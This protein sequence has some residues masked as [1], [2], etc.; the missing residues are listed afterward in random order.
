MPLH[1]RTIV[2]MGIHFVFLVCLALWDAALRER[3]AMPAAFGPDTAEAGSA[4]GVQ[5]L[6]MATAFV[7]VECDL[8]SGDTATD[9][10]NPDA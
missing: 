4:R 8:R 2:S 6:K 1:V 7:P 5:Q 10:P 9:L 3:R